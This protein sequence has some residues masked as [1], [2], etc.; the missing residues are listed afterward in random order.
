MKPYQDMPLELAQRC[1][2]CPNLRSRGGGFECHASAP[3]CRFKAVREWRKEHEKAPAERVPDRNGLEAAKMRLGRALRIVKRL[4]E[5]NPGSPVLAELKGHLE[6][7]S[8]AMRKGD[9]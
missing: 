5:R 2:A 6:G 3:A 8:R 7:A 9:S 1:L 4:E